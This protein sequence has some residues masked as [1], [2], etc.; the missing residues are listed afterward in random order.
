MYF[1]VPTVCH[2]RPRMRLAP[3]NTLLNILVNIWKYSYRMCKN[4]LASSNSLISI[5]WHVI[6][7]KLRIGR[8]NFF[9][10]K[11]FYRLNKW[12]LHLYKGKLFLSSKTSMPRARRDICRQQQGGNSALL[13]VVRKTNLEPYI[14]KHT[15]S[16]ALGYVNKTKIALSST[17]L[18]FVITETFQCSNTL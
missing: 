18:G 1:K 7:G 16:T 4:K 14:R 11:H 17:M 8:S 15:H 13:P 12:P 2:P 10:Q 9:I 6:R 5:T 3:I